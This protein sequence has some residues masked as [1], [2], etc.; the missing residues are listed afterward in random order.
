MGFTYCRS[1]V[2]VFDSQ[3]SSN[4]NTYVYIVFIPNCLSLRVSECTC[5]GNDMFRYV[6]E[7]K[8]WLRLIFLSVLMWAI[9]ISQ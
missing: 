3:K 2:C 7:A 9:A 8:N 4:S 5:V 6:C 1:V